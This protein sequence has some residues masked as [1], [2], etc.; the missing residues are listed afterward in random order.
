MRLR[1]IYCSKSNL[2]CQRFWR[3]AK[4]TF[5]TSKC[6]LKPFETREFWTRNSNLKKNHLPFRSHRIQDCIVCVVPA[7]R[8]WWINIATL[9]FSA[10]MSYKWITFSLAY[11]LTP[12]WRC[13]CEL[14]SFTRLFQHTIQNFIIYIISLFSFSVWFTLSSYISSRKSYSC[15][16][17][18]Y[19]V[20]FDFVWS[21][22]IIDINTQCKTKAKQNKACKQK[23]S[24][25]DSIKWS[26][27]NN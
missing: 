2:N 7:M 22:K 14:M 10:R 16:S 8:I 24:L 4:A 25:I 23:H 19:A 13:R 1:T 21:V 17:W 27:L 15:S 6:Q 11:N 9:F 26:R 20:I 12:R 18:K 3:I 5:V